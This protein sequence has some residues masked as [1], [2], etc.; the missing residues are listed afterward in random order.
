[1]HNM[2]LILT[3]GNSLIRMQRCL[4]I[5]RKKFAEQGCFSCCYFVA[6]ADHLSARLHQIRPPF[7]MFRRA[8]ASR[9]NF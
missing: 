6:S 4:L 5:N 1:M 8:R 7:E 9:A 2:H 3:K